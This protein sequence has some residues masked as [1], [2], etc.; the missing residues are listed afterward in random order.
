MKTALSLSLSLSFLCSFVE[1]GILEKE[2]GG[3]GGRAYNGI[4]QKR[5]AG[6]GG[7]GG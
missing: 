4:C 5:G 7:G 1:G 2:E 6:R 3:K